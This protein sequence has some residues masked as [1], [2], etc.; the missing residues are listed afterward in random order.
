MRVTIRYLST[1]PRW[2]IEFTTGYHHPK[3][4]GYDTTHIRGIC[5]YLQQIL[6]PPINPVKPPYYMVYNP[7]MS[8]IM[9]DDNA[10]AL[11]YGMGGV[12][13]LEFDSVVKLYFGVMRYMQMMEG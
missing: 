3:T 11:E 4:R 9:I 6:V 2:T 1:A 13:P 10:M 8:E 7:V 5:D 12:A